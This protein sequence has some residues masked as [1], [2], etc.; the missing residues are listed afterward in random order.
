MRWQR[1]IRRWLD[2][3]LVLRWLDLRHVRCR[4]RLRLRLMLRLLH[5][6]EIRIQCL[7]WWC[8]GSDGRR[9]GCG[10]SG[11][12]SD[13]RGRLSDQRRV[14]ECSLHRGS[15]AVG[16]EDLRDLLE[17][18]RELILQLGLTTIEGL[19]RLN[20]LGSVLG[21]GC[22][23][24]SLLLGS[25]RRQNRIVLLP[26]PIECALACSPRRAR[27]SASCHTACSFDSSA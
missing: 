12:G 27:D 20:L 25:Q 3:W 1:R 11:R 7:D 24:A 22:L 10:R 19:A 26:M 14:R 13:S 23:D 17:R 5:H 2:R 6:V 9:G 8:C 15:V 16:A 4:L 21:I 18:A